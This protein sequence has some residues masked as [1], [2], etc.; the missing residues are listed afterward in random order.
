MQVCEKKAL[1]AAASPGS[2]ASA[3][4]TIASSTQGAVKMRTDM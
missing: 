1:P 3:A 4:P 2:A